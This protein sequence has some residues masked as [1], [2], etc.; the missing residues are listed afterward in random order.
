MVSG[1][2]VPLVVMFVDSSCSTSSRE[3]GTKIHLSTLYS[4]GPP[5][6]TGRDLSNAARAFSKMYGR[7]GFDSVRMWTLEEMR[8]VAP[9]LV[10][11]Y[12]S[13]QRAP[14]NPGLH[15]MGFMAFK[16]FVMLE[17]FDRMADGDIIVFRD[18]NV[19]KYKSYRQDPGHLPSLARFVLD[20]TGADLYMPPQLP[21]VW[22]MRHHC[23]ASLLRE[24]GVGLYNT[25]HPGHPDHGKAGAPTF[26]DFAKAATGEQLKTLELLYNYPLPFAN[27]IFAR[28]S[29]Q[30]RK[31]LEDWLDA[32]R[33]SNWLTVRTHAAANH[34]QYRW[35]TPEQ[36][37]FGVLSVKW[38][39]DGTVPVDFPRFTFEGRMVSWSTVKRL[40]AA[41][42]N[43]SQPTSQNCCVNGELAEACGRD[44]TWHPG[45]TA[46]SLGLPR[47]PWPRRLPP[48]VPSAASNGGTL[49][50]RG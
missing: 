22:R 31:L 33:H 8:R 35:H 4:Q 41:W 6:D 40:D 26:E 28:K 13:S 45:W 23:K 17:A 20:N 46:D 1:L 34:P 7:V 12:P 15:T 2:L 9:E 19:L 25:S 43:A 21:K 47:T 39:L 16:P 11:E 10:K 24:L 30:G 37:V 36:C 32:C 42:L 50:A 29:P 27:T 48:F 38:I 3:E 44:R 5:H 14:R 49:V 18:T